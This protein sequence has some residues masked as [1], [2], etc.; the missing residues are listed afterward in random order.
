MRFAFLMDP[1]EQVL[2]DKDTTFALMLEAQRRG[3]EVYTV[4]SGDL[5]A[6]TGGLFANASRTRVRRADRPG[7]FERD[8][9][10]ERVDVAALDAVF[11]RTDPPFDAQYLYNTLLLERV[12][13]KT[14]VV[15]DPRG[16][17]DANE[18]LYAMHFPEVTPRTIVTA[19]EADVRAF[20]EEIGGPGVMKPL[21]GAGGRGIMVVD[22]NDKNFRSIV[23]TLT[24]EGRRFAMVQEFLPAVREG[25]KRVLLLDGEPLGAILRVPRADESRSNI[26]VGGRVEPCEL[27]E[28]D[29][30]IVAAVAD[31]LRR[32]GLYFVG[33]DVIGG[34]LTEVNVTSPTGIQELSRFTGSEPEAK[35]IAWVETRA[36][37]VNSGAG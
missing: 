20:L 29:R 36:K 3:H 22:L 23:E 31:R 10:P 6:T 5:L 37:A 27:D 26:H 21:D 16:V 1:I 19:R 34:R 11:V 32:D 17:R 35:V 30:T 7:H 33:L 2:V 4:G 13:G 12:R 28:R 15:N 25:D 18:K 14:L 9:A 24:N 8:G